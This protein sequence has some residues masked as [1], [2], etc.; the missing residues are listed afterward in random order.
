M[1]SSQTLVVPGRIK[2]NPDNPRL[3]FRPTELQ[4]LEDSIKLQGILVP[5]SVYEKGREYVLL[6]GERR[7][8]CALK[9]GLPHVPVVVQAEPDRLQN[10][11]MMFAIHNA[12]TDWDPL[13]TAYKLQELEDEYFRRQGF[14]PNEAELAEVASISRGEVRRLRQLL[15]LPEEYRAELM[16]ELDK[17]RSQQ[18]LTVDHVLEANK[19]AASLRSRQIISDAEEA[20]LRRAIVNKFRARVETNTVEPRQLM[21]MSRAVE[22]HEVAPDTVRTLARKLIKEPEFTIKKAFEASAAGVDFQHGSQQLAGRLEQR[23]LEQLGRDYA[24]SSE[25]RESLDR[26]YRVLGRVL[27]KR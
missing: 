6:D 13:P 9:L 18:I 21:R 22:R 15:A 20:S 23:L 4:A 7:W 17:P 12:R 19:G 26:L 10:I 14:R 16:A 3:I 2:A 24:L 25:L 27:G 8:R 1:A 5:L 11:M